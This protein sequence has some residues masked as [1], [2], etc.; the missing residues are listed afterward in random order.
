[1]KWAIAVM[2]LIKKKKSSFIIVIKICKVSFTKYIILDY[3]QHDK[4]LTE[5]IRRCD[6]LSPSSTPS[7]VGEGL[8]QHLGLASYRD[9]WNK[10]LLRKLRYSFSTD[11]FNEI[12]DDERYKDD[13]IDM[14][15]SLN[16]LDLLE[17]IFITT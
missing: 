13:K 12:K 9:S 3:H 15:F 14:T 1:M 10:G 8:R 6:S 16:L 7:E 2:F 4:P 5:K 17:F 11:K